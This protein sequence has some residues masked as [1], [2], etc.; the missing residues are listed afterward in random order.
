MSS[1]EF[2]KM[3]WIKKKNH[4]IWVLKDVDNY[5][6][7]LPQLTDEVDTGQ[8]PCPMLPGLLEVHI[9]LEPRS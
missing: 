8:A 1:L 7:Q 2:N 9:E 5:L 4:N 3:I 6:V